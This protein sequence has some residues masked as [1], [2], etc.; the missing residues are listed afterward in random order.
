MLRELLEEYGTVV[1]IKI[2]IDERTNRLRDFGFVDMEDEDEGQ[3]AIRN[4]D[5][6]DLK[7]R[8]LWVKEAENRSPRPDAG[9]GDW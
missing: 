6:S 4:L 8:T 5:I 3:E 7:G 1:S 9:R 2:A